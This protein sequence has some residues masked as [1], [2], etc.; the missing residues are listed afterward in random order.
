[1]IAIEVLGLFTLLQGS[2]VGQYYAPPGRIESDASKPGHVVILPGRLGASGELRAFEGMLETYNIGS[3]NLSTQ[4]WDW[5][6]TELPKGVRDDRRGSSQANRLRAKELS[7]RLRVWRLDHIQEKAYLV[8]LGEGAWIATLA[9]EHL[10]DEFFE[11][12]LFLSAAI[13]TSEI[14]LDMLKRRTRGSTGFFN[15]SSQQDGSLGTAKSRVVGYDGFD[16]GSQVWSLR[17]QSEHRKLGNWGAHL[18][19]LNQDFAREKLLPVFHDDRS[20][21]K[22][23]GWREQ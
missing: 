4:I 16:P 7:E 18:Q 22:E 10:P 21:A 14:G 13:S 2:V 15:Y 11:R 19:C 8:A 23:A 12:I 20:R 5:T 1:M 17:W 9:C 3:G 6:R